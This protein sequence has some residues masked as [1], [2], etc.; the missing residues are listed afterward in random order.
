VALA[1][2]TK[3]KLSGPYSLF[4]SKGKEVFNCPHSEGK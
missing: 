4:D 3:G 1:N 2:M